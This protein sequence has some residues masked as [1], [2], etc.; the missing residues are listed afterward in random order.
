LALL[1]IAKITEEA[2]EEAREKVLVRSGRID[3]YL[4]VRQF[5]FEII[6]RAKSMA[7]RDFAAV[8]VCDF[9]EILIFV[10]SVFAAPSVSPS[11][12]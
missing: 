5:I 7:A 12:G 10:S 6:E 9:E 8:E 3:H 4:V 1:L 11:V 2:V